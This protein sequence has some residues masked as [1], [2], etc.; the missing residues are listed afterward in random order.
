MQNEQN[1]IGEVNYS[2]IENDKTNHNLLIYFE[3]KSEESI[4]ESLI[5]LGY[6]I[7]I[8]T[9]DS[10]EFNTYFLNTYV[11]KSVEENV[12]KVINEVMSNN[13]F[14]PE[15]TI[16]LGT[17]SGGSAALY[18][19]MKIG[20]EHVVVANPHISIGTFVKK[21]WKDNMK[22]IAG[23]NY[24]NKQISFWD[25]IIPDEFKNAT[26]QPNIHAL[27]S[28]NKKSLAEL[29]ALQV[30]S[31]SN[32]VSLDTK[33][34]NV[35]SLYKI[36]KPFL[37]FVKVNILDIFYGL[38]LNK[39]ALKISEGKLKCK[40]NGN[41]PS[42]ELYKIHLFFKSSKNEGIRYPINELDTINLS[43]IINNSSRM[44]KYT[45]GIE[46]TLIK[47]QKTI[48][49]PNLK[50]L[51][52]NP[53]YILLEPQLFIK[54]DRLHYE[55]SVFSKSELK[56]ASELLDENNEPIEK[57]DYSNNLIGAFDLNNS[58]IYKLK[59]YFLNKNKEHISKPLVV[60]Y[61]ESDTKTIEKLKKENKNLK[62]QNK[63]LS[64]AG[65]KLL[66]TLINE[67]KQKIELTEK[68]LAMLQKESTLLKSYKKLQGKYNAL[69][70][71]KLGKLTKQYWKFIKK[72]KRG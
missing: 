41:M 36:N 67:K 10:S 28:D 56:V 18:Y 35:N 25:E 55:L 59:F 14:L 23:S 6:N 68:V 24:T 19:S 70:D 30:L 13:A 40:I 20:V 72:V 48:T 39:F 58:G 8:F 54:D 12:V 49:V 60:K 65:E 61:K 43:D 57:V 47:E 31:D 71:S 37:D 7:L 42:K 62:K 33:I 11:N 34:S 3:E 52:I 63:Q 66:A 32:Q 1:S 64:A 44:E 5:A 22:Y 21:H 45:A 27:F 15:N 51:Y 17:N 4:A 9:G 16:M 53:N 46:V 26:V 38:K 2:L 69:N 29:N 50:T